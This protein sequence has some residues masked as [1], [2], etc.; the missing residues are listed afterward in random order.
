MYQSQIR[1]KKRGR[2][3]KKKEFVEVGDDQELAIVED[4]LGN[5]RVRLYCEDKKL[6]IGRIRGSLRKYS[7]KMLI[8]RGDLVITSTRDFG[9]GDMVDIIHKYSHEDVSTLLRHGCVPEEI[10]KKLRQG[11]DMDAEGPGD[12]Y[13]MFMDGEEASGEPAGAAGTASSDAEEEP[14]DG[15]DSDV[16]VDAI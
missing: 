5:G 11:D 9:N 12:N 10:Q 6:R 13:V 7:N 3:M 8:Y 14:G 4:L 15:E 2:H 16:D 1:S